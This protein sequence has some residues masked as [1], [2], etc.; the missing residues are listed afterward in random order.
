MTLALSLSNATK[1]MAETQ[2]FRFRLECRCGWEAWDTR[3]WVQYRIR[4][5]FDYLNL[6]G[7]D[8]SDHTV[9]I[10]PAEATRSNA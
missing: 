8:A 5:H 10:A 1:V 7:D 6:P 4:K 9:D 3:Y 2:A